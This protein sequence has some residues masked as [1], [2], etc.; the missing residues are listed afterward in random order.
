MFVQSVVGYVIM[1]YHNPGDYSVKS[2]LL[3]I[4]NLIF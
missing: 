4:S 2:S 3:L 1:Q